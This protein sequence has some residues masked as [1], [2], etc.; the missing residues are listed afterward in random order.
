MK[1]CKNIQNCFLDK[2]FFIFFNLLVCCFFCFSCS[3]NLWNDDSDSDDLITWVSIGGNT[4]DT[5]AYYVS[6]NGNDAN[7]G[8]KET[9]A[10]KTIE[11]AI[12]AVHPGGEIRILAGVYNEA[13]GIINSG[14]ESAS[15]TI[16]GFNAIPV[17][18][19]RNIDVMGIF[20]E[21]CKNFTFSNLQ[22]QNYTDLGIGISKCIGI[23]LKNLIVKENG[24]AVQLKDWEFEGYGIHVEESKRVII[25]DNETYRNGPDP[26]IV[27]TYLMGTGINTYANSDVLI[28]NNISHD[29]IGGGILVEDSHNVLVDS[30]E[31]YNNDLDASV[32]EWW[33][34]G[35]WLDGGY[36]VIIRDNHFY[37]NLGPGIVISNEDFQ[38][39]YG[40]ILENNVSTN[41]YYGIFIWNFGTNEWPDSTIL[42]R[43][44]NQFTENSIQNVWIVDWY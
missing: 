15:V 32:D 36:D 7:D 33:D 1:I 40:Y 4:I 28:R 38:N 6:N 24:H 44:N 8:K 22:I 41:N 3:L 11:R 12:K 39:P 37:N 14:S 2:Y 31:V 34:G 16:T 5:T 17:L 10:F 19:G 18:D 23:T 35:I 25:I 26:Q 13:L 29:N 21:N 9:T 27:P 42:Q 43:S 20:C 30:N